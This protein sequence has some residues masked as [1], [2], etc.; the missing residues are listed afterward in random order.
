MSW[1]SPPI[2]EAE[3]AEDP[4]SG[5]AA[6]LH[7][8]GWSHMEN[9]LIMGATGNV[10]RQVV[11][12]LLAT[13]VRVRAMARSPENTRKAPP[14]TLRNSVNCSPARVSR[15]SKIRSY[16]S[17]S[18]YPVAAVFQSCQAFKH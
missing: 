10:G 14:S 15:P 17:R 18:G 16:P 9:I 12:Q 1:R 11:S 4:A 13:D 2:P 6:P 5:L 3:V 8:V 7:V